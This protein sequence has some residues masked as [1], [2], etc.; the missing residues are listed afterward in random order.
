[1]VILS[2]LQMAVKT[3]LM[4]AKRWCLAI[5]LKVLTEFQWTGLCQNFKEENSSSDERYI[6]WYFLSF[7][8]LT[9]RTLFLSFC[10]LLRVVRWKA[11]KLWKSLHHH[12]N[13]VWPAVCFTEPN[14][15]MAKML[16]VR[17]F[18]LAAMMFDR[19]KS[20]R[21]LLKIVVRKNRDLDRQN[22]F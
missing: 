8:K 10:T 5:I 19:R 6:F 18:W 22:Y 15:F 7:N 14:L 21:L 20:F 11:R 4:E 1:M 2:D 16:S 3:K 17:T 12:I 13:D 9:R